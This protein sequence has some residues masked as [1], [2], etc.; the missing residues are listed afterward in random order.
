[1]KE[2]RKTETAEELAVGSFSEEDYEDV[3]TTKFGRRFF[4]GYK[5][6]TAA[7]RAFQDINREI[8]VELARITEYGRRTT[9]K[10]KPGRKTSL[11]KLSIKLRKIAIERGYKPL[12]RLEWEVIDKKQLDSREN[13][14]KE[15][16]KEWLV[17]HEPILSY[18]DLSSEETFIVKKR[19]EDRVGTT[20][21]FSSSTMYILAEMNNH[22]LFDEEDLHRSSLSNEE[23]NEVFETISSSE[24]SEEDVRRWNTS[25]GRILRSGAFSTAQHLRRS[26]IRGMAALFNFSL[27]LFGIFGVV[28]Y[29]FFL[30]LLSRKKQPLPT[31]NGHIL[32]GF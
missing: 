20:R 30:N 24:I 26:E 11:Q 22:L 13:L 31:G 17:I 19:L 12:T 6:K 3:V 15:F 14:V 2:E 7:A 25:Q 9:N 18:R 32:R 28:V 1:M 27:L 10:Q 21:L 23:I 5:T 8:A 4:K 29:L 16:G